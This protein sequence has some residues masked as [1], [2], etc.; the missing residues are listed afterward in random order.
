V[1]LAAYIDE[2]GRHDKT[3]QKQGS[4]SIIVGGWVDKYEN[5]PEFCRKWQ[6][7]LKKYDVPYFHFYEWVDAVAV[8]RKKR[9][10]SSSF[11]KNPCR[12]LTFQ[13]L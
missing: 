6:A 2:S 9:K 11:A 3:G 4:A 13:K 7:V 1:K 8:A 12:N 5:W 10:P